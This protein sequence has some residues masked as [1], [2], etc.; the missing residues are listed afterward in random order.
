MWV[1]ACTLVCVWV[2]MLISLYLTKLLKFKPKR[3]SRGSPSICEKAV[4]PSTNQNSRCSLY[5]SIRWNLRLLKN[6]L[7]ERCVDRENIWEYGLSLKPNGLLPAL[8]MAQIK[9][10]PD[11]IPVARSLLIDWSPTG[12]LTPCCPCFLSSLLSVTWEV[13]TSHPTS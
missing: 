12:V 3:G 1:C 9:A 8:H 11:L 10:S 6:N 4:C 7:S 13:Q 5:T 2:R